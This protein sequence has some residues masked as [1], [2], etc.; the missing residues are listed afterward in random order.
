MPDTLPS[1]AL[2][3][4]DWIELYTATGI[5]PRTPLSLQVDGNHP[6]E[7]VYSD[8]K[9]TT[10]RGLV[11]YPLVF[12]N[13]AGGEASIWARATKSLS[14]TSVKVAPAGAITESVIIESTKQG[15]LN[16]SGRFFTG[17]TTRENVTVLDP[18][19]HSVITA[20][21]NGAKIDDLILAINFSDITDGRFT[22][23]LTCWAENS[24]GSDWSYTP[25]APAPMGRSM[26][27]AYINDFPD[28]T[29]DSDVAAT[30]NSG[31]AD[32][33]IY[34]SDYYLDTT[35][36]RQIQTKSETRFFEADRQLI[37][38]PNEKVLVRAEV[39]GDATGDADIKSIFF[40]A[41]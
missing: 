5:A 39:S 14:P 6:A 16:A 9:P 21:P 23:E 36:N 7:I 18:P 22:Y 15:E 40:L 10:M 20:G 37:I 17:A 28:T 2:T 3:H 33:T 29:Y 27:T 34:F 35:G 38:A 19:R 32:Y 26:N 8:I 25:S 4:D 24:N 11:L 1:V 12:K 30:I 31:T 41:E 13:S